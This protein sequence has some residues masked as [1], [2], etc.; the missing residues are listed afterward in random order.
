MKVKNTWLSRL[1]VRLDSNKWAIII[2]FLI[3]PCLIVVPKRIIQEIILRHNAVFVNATVVKYEK[4]T[5]AKRG[6]WEVI[7]FLYEYDG[8]YYVNTVRNKSARSYAINE[9]VLIIVNKNKPTQSH[10]WNKQE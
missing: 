1:L 4:Y 3:S 5:T 8:N 9:Q 10:L 2:W 7:S 6:M